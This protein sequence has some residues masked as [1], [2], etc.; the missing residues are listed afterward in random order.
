MARTKGKMK[1]RTI[2][3]LIGIGVA[4]IGGGVAFAYFTG[5]GG[6]SGTATTGSNNPVVVK[7]TSTLTAVA[8]GVAPQALSGVFDNPNPGPVYV[9]AVSAAVTLTATPAGCSASDYT[10]AGTGAVGREIPAGLNQGTWNGLTIAF[11]NKAGTNQDGCKNAAV[12]ITY[13]AS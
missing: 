6:G 9:T 4:V 2:A 5:V 8:P 11:N 1:T 10:I 3:V 7:Q 12:T 13:T